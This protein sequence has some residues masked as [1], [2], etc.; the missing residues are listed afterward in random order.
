[1]YKGGVD[2]AKD[3]RPRE[4]YRR[5]LLALGI[6]SFILTL[7]SFICCTVSAPYISSSCD[8][9]EECTKDMIQKGGC[10]NHPTI[11]KECNSTCFTNSTC[12]ADGKCSQG[13]CLGD[14]TSALDCPDSS[15]TTS[16]VLGTCTYIFPLTEASEEVCSSIEDECLS[17]SFTPGACVGTYKCSQRNL[18]ILIPSPTPSPTVSSG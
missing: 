17:F 4:R 2:H 9:G 1:M 16:C 14:C 12:G 10:L 8:D 7:G 11:G 3:T 5:S 15:G 13:I 6:I 18:E